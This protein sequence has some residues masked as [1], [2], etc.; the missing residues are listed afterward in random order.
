MKFIGLLSLQDAAVL[1][2]YGKWAG[3]TIE[4][5]MGGSTMIF[6]Q[7]GTKLWSLEPNPEWIDRTK[8]NLD[9]LKIDPS[10]YKLLEYTRTLQGTEG[11][12]FDLAFV[13][14]TE[15]TRF[16]FAIEAFK[17]LKMGGWMLFHDTRQRTDFRN[18]L[19]TL[20]VYQ[21]EI[22][23]V[24]VN[25]DHSNIT[26]LKKKPPEPYY[27]WEEAEGKERWMYNL[28]DVPANWPDLL[29]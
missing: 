26:G 9:L 16:P 20:M 6:A 25:M 3:K 11:E 5:G 24:K 17:R 15:E 19:D 14:G 4:L 28:G 1:E 18:A 27:V 2:K 10:R 7:A 12:L 22:D 21:N 8:A 23:E 13:D 29:P